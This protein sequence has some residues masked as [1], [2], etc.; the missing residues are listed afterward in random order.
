MTTEKRPSSTAQ[1]QADVIVRNG[2]IATQDERRSF[3]STV[4]IKDGCFLAVGTDTE[5]MPHKG[6]A[7]QVIDVGGR[8]VIPG[9]HDSHLHLIRGGLNYIAGPFACMRPTMGRL[10]MR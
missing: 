3:A 1:K 8:T 2:R 10:P 5:V 7:T 4:A 9:L 6:A